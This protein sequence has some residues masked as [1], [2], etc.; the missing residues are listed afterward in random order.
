MGDDRCLGAR[1][2]KNAPSSWDEGASMSI[3]NTHDWIAVG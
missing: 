3:G 1:G 2:T